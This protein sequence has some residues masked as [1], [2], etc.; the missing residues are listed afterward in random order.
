MSRAAFKAQ[1]GCLLPTA[2]CLLSSLAAWLR[3][4]VLRLLA[5]GRL[6][7]RGGRRLVG[8]DGRGLDLL[9]RVA[10]LRLAVIYGRVGR[11]DLRL[12]RLR[13]RVLL[14]H[15]ILCLCD[16]LGLAMCRL[17]GGE[18]AE[19]GARLEAFVAEYLRRTGA[20][21][22]LR[23]RAVGDDLPVVRKLVQPRFELVERDVGRALDLRRGPDAHVED[24]DFALGAQELELFER[25]A[26]GRNLRRL[27]RGALT[28]RARRQRAE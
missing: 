26:V 18:A 4:V 20:G 9:R 1:P 15:G 7:R 19:Q 10:G 21:V 13:V 11:G 17:P 24:K 5:P 28:L 2:F 3:L 8:V 6:Q 14:R 27:R 16:R 25:D 12:R 22:L 23:S